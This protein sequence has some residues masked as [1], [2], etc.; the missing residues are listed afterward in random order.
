MLEIKKKYVV[1][2]DKNT[3]DLLGEKCFKLLKNG[4]MAN[5]CRI[6]KAER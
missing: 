6:R 2:K 1:F 3:G 5:G 4:L